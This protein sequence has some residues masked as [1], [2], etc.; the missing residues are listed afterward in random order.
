[1]VV[2][3]ASHGRS[4]LVL[5][6]QANVGDT[7]IAF[8]NLRLV[9]CNGKRCGWGRP[10][11][12]DIDKRSDFPGGSE[13]VLIGCCDARRQYGNGTERELIAAAKI[14]TSINCWRV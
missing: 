8:S 3:S 4:L 11:L 10:V 12:E 14:Y 9:D 2:G 6:G 5:T 1:M 7:K 13:V